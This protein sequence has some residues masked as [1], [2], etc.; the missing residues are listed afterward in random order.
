MYEPVHFR[1]EDREAVFGLVR[2][3][4]FGLL[5]SQGAE[6]IIAN[7]LP[8][9]LIEEGEAI[10]LRAHVARPNP[11]WQALAA[12]PE[13]LVVFQGVQHYVTPAWYPSKRE[14][15]KVVPTWNYTHVQMRGTASIRE[16][17]AFL[18]LQ[19]GALTARHEAGRS[20]PWA[21]S[22]APEAYVAAQLR[23]IV[24]I[25]IRV[26]SWQ[27]KFK[28]SQNR[29]QAERAGVIAGL[30]GEVAEDA[31]AVAGLM[32]APGGEKTI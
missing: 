4:P 16:D 25:E 20:E 11:Q 26:S 8:F 12:N 14:H 23:G 31:R 21:V 2:A 7:P 18:R 27:G 3:N 13:A 5:I 32:A 6:G 15:G 1:V 29:T 24:G 10:I 30:A 28:L 19:V 17:E 9:L 22:D